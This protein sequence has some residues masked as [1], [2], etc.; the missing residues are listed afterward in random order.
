MARHSNK[1]KVLTG[2]AYA[3][4]DIECLKLRCFSPH[5]SKQTFSQWTQRVRLGPM[6]D[7]GATVNIIGYSV[8]R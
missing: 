2:K 3:S 8:L 4:R 5:G 7:P 6:R 1:V